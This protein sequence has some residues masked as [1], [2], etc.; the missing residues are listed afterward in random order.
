MHRWVWD[1]HYPSPESERHEYPIS[2]V[3]HDTPRL[4]LGPSAVAGQYTVRLTVG[5]KSYTAPL[6]VKMDPRVKTPPAGLERKFQMETR[7]A[8][9]MNQSYEATTQARSV[10]EQLQKLA[11]QASGPA[12]EAIAALDK[13]VGAIL[14]APGGFLVPVS[15]APTLSK[16]GGEVGTLYGMAGG[17]DAAPTTS[18]MTAMAAVE[19]DFSGVIKRWDEIKTTDI[20]G[21][22]QQLHGANLPE[23]NLDRKPKAEAESEGVE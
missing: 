1:L 8:G 6:I 15:P 22:N 3:P 5:G 13:K 23:I 20:P 16:V 12:G 10:R 11:P 17:A 9:M 19:R 21:L 2:A 7:L 4:P 14:G 18:Q